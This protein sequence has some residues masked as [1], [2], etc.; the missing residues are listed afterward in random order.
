[1]SIA[2]GVLFKESSDVGRVRRHAVYLVGRPP[3]VALLSGA[4]LG[5]EPGP[6]AARRTSRRGPPGRCWMV[7]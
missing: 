2:V 6:G 3:V 5:S 1:M 7:P 4:C